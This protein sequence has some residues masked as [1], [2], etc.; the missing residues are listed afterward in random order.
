[1]SDY[2]IEELD[3]WYLDTQPI[4][5]RGQVNNKVYALYL[6]ELCDHIWEISTTGSIIR[7]NHLPKWG[8][9][10]KIC[11]LCKKGHNKPYKE[12]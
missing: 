3:L 4:P 12:E 9:E 8:K 1:M 10:K 5:K 11:K 7:Y 6:C 2:D